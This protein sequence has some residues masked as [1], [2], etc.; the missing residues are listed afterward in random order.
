MAEKEIPYT[1]WREFCDRFA[2]QHRGWLVSIDTRQTPGAAQAP[3]TRV[4]GAEEHE[5]P[6]RQVVHDVPL[7][8]LTAVPN[9]HGTS[10]LLET[11]GDSHTTRI[12]VAQPVR[13]RLQTAPD[14]ADAGLCIDDADGQITCLEFRVAA[15]PELTDGMVDTE[16]GPG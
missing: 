1:Q 7:Q 13:V 2:Q 15:R 3:Q 6:G 5:Q 9:P 4:A 10:L 8:S 12:L 16:L 14:G 11:G